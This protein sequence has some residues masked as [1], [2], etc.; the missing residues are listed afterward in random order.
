VKGINRILITKIN[1]VVVIDSSTYEE[2]E[3]E[4]INVELL[5]Q[6]EGEREPNQIL[7]IALSDD[8]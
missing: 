8:E 5:A 3:N 1:K 7:S 6:K 2:R 4:C